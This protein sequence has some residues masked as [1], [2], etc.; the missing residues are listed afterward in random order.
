MSIVPVPRL[1][2]HSLG[3]L[4]FHYWNTLLSILPGTQMSLYSKRFLCSGHGEGE[5]FQILGICKNSFLY[6]FLVASGRFFTH[7]CQSV[8]SSNA[9]RA[10]RHL[11]SSVSETLLPVSALP[12]AFQPL[13]FPAFS[14]PFSEHSMSVRLCLG[15]PS[16]CSGLETLS[17]Q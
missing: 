15:F 2:N 16:L 1:R 7:V 3:L 5:L 4:G 9:N 11:Q 13:G 17:E 14:A 10:F 12:F 8:Y 6:S